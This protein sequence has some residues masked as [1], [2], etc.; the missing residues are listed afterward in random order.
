MALP[1]P[2]PK[3]KPPLINKDLLFTVP[4]KTPSLLPLSEKEEQKEAPFFA[5]VKVLVAMFE[6]CF[7][8]EIV[9]L[10]RLKGKKT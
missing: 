10:K 8:V 6:M 5:T 2:R 7:S 3:P 1:F 9:S 4:E